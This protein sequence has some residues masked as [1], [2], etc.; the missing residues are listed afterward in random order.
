MNKIEIQARIEAINAE[1]TQMRTNYAKLEGH[2]SEARHWIIEI[3]RRE[4]EAQSEKDKV[5]LAQN[6]VDA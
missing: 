3:E 4:A 5:E 1:M 2:L 6:E